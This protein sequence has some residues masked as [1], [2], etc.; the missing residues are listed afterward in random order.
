MK[1]N[2][3][4]ERCREMGITDRRL[5]E[6]S[7]VPFGTVNHW[8]HVGYGSARLSEIAKVSRVLGLSLDEIVGDGERR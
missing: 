1:S 4:R 3:L 2:R 7:G 6:L 5:S 8:L